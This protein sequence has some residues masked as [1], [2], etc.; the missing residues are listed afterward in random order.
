MVTG[1]QNDSAYGVERRRRAQRDLDDI[2]AA[3]KQRAAERDRV[4]G[5]LDGDDRGKAFQTL[6]DW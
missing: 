3:I 4:L 6:S 2:Q 5:S 1:H